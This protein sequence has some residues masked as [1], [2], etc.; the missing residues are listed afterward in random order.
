M[1]RHLAAVLIGLAAS[2]VSF[3]AQAQD[4]AISYTRTACP[5]KEAVSYAKCDGK[6][7][8]IK[9][10]E[11]ASPE[12]CQAAALKACANDRLDI[13]K[14]KVINASYKGSALKSSSGSADFCVDY[15]KR[16]AEFDKCGG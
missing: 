12:A 2:S 3:I 13:T 1:T 4:C 9:K 10:V 11:A 6:Q 14:S 16:A 7:S 5:G 15:D 8:C